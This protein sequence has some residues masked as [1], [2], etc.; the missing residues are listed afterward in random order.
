VVATSA[1][2]A[3]IAV[4]TELWLIWA[5]IAIENARAARAARAAL[6][7]DVEAGGQP[8]LNIELRPVLLAI[9]AVATSLDGFA[10]EVE[11]TGVRVATPNTKEPT[12]A[13]WIWETLRGGFDVG[14]K[15]NTWPRDLKDVFRLRVGGLHPRT[16]F[17]QPIHHPVMPNVS[18]TRAIYTTEAADAAVALMLD[19]YETCRTA[20]RPTYSALVSRMSGLDAAMARLSA[21]DLSLA[22]TASRQPHGERT[23]LTSVRRRA[24]SRRRSASG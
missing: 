3:Q 6:M 7:A 1:V 2:T 10:A 23:Q 8:D 12:R 11:K 5:D 16:V 21:S 20:V 18:P 4:G 9:A 19:V 14:S 17:G 13:H 24:C 15:T 22:S